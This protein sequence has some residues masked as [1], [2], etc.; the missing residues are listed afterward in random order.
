MGTGYILGCN[1]CATKEDIGNIYLNE[2]EDDP[3]IK[4]NIFEIS[5]GGGMLCFCKEQLEKIYGIDKKYDRKYRLLACGDPP[6]ELYKLIGSMTE[7]KNIDK[8]IFQKITEGF[9]F[10]ENLGHFPYYC[11]NCKTLITHFYL[12][13]K[14]D[15]FIYTPEYKCKDCSNILSPATW[16]DTDETYD[17]DEEDL[18]DDEDERE[19][20]NF[21]YNIYVE[22][23]IIKIKSNEGEKKLICKKCGNDQFS[24]KSTIFFD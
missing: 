15:N 13:L 3:T 23:E 4:P 10:T 20:L 16:N 12:E 11:E 17:E 6:E 21:K 5:L 18:E 9:E 24:I 2:N 14:K 7:D 8:I 19:E 1:K 22:N